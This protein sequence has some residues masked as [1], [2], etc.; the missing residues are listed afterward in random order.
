LS[1]CPEGRYAGCEEF[2]DDLRRWLGGD[3]PLA[4]RH[5][6]KRFRP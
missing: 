1:K 4:Y 2:A 5:T 6:W 3:T